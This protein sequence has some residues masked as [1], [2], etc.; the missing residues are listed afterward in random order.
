MPLRDRHIP[1][2]EVQSEHNRKRTICPSNILLPIMS[3][4]QSFTEVLDD[5]ALLRR[6]VIPLIVVAD[7]VRHVVHSRCRDRLDARIIRCCRDGHAQLFY[8]MHSL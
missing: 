7:A 4:Q 3:F 5:L 6:I 8:L 2:R 1:A